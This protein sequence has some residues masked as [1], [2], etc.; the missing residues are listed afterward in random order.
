MHIITMEVIGKRLWE[1]LKS[2]LSNHIQ[3][4]KGKKNKEIT[5]QKGSEERDRIL[6]N[7]TDAS[8]NGV[9]DYEDVA[10]TFCASDADSENDLPTEEPTTPPLSPSSQ[11]IHEY[12]KRQLYD[13]VSSS[14]LST[15]NDFSEIQIKMTDRQKIRSA[16]IRQKERSAVLNDIRDQKD[17]RKRSYGSDFNLWIGSGLNKYREVVIILPMITFLNYWCIKIREYFYH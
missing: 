16:K 2:Q 3:Y 9:D 14:S 15:A 11:S 7:I 8:E 1:T 4:K 12:D 17:D 10:D 6:E 5:S 13:S